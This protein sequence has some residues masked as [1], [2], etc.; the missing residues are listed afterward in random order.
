[1]GRI[2]GASGSVFVIREAIHA[3]PPSLQ[4][5]LILRHYGEFSYSKI[6]EH[7]HCPIGTARQ[8][9][10]TAI[11]HLRQRLCSPRKEEKR[12]S[13]HQVNGIQLLEY[14]YGVLP[15]DQH[16]DVHA[17]LAGCEEAQQE[18]QQ[19]REVMSSLNH[20]VG[21]FLLLYLVELDD[22]GV[23][24]YYT[25]GRMTNTTAQPMTA[26]VMINAA[27]SIADFAAFQGEAVRSKRNRGS[28]IPRDRLYV[29]HL[30]TPVLP[31]ESFDGMVVSHMAAHTQELPDKAIEIAAGHWRFSQQL[32]LGAQRDATIIVQGIRLPR[33]AELLAAHPPVDA[34]KQDGATTVFWRFM[35][36]PERPLEISIEY[37]R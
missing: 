24:T 34:V 20:V 11:Q 15:A 6:A 7:C 8:R 32:G 31:G 22:A 27:G 35:P 23:A 37:R 21:D 18:L 13:G 29:A 33:G 9:V 30:P 14:L 25:W 4:Q 12:M 17:Q 1:M 36:A 16:A 2:V 5:V 3:L 19:L 28:T 10:W 26:F